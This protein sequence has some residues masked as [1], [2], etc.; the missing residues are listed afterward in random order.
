MNSEFISNLRVRGQIF[1]PLK[2]LIRC[3]TYKIKNGYLQLKK[4]HNLCV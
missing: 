2:Y 1:T 4:K 3:T